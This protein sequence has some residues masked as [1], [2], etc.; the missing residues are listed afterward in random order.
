MR[1]TANL[2]FFHLNSG[3]KSFKLSESLYFFG[4]YKDTYTNDI[5]TFLQEQILSDECAA[6]KSATRYIVTSWYSR[7]NSHFYLLRM[8]V[9]ILAT[10]T[11]SPMSERDFSI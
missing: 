9:Q 8:A 5:D 10:P 7:L 2:V 11:S 1:A 6:L 3:K 4:P